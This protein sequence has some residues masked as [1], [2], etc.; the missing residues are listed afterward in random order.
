MQSVRFVVDEKG[1]PA[2]VQIDIDAWEGL[3]DWLEDVD[4]IVEAQWLSTRLLTWVLRVRV[5]STAPERRPDA[6]ASTMKPEGGGRLFDQPLLEACCRQ[7]RTTALATAASTSA[8]QCVDTAFTFVAF[9]DGRN[10]SSPRGH[11]P[12]W[13]RRAEAIGPGC[14]RDRLNCTPRSNV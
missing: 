3:L 7:W 6:K 2:A 8:M 12:C 11:R 5:P 4:F 9:E 10:L 13:P 14:E 1:Q